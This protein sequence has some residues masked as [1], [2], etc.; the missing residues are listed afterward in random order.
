MTLQ[1]MR[2]TIARR[3]EDFRKMLKWSQKE[4]AEKVDGL[5]ASSIEKIEK[6]EM[7]PSPQ[8]LSRLA[9]ALGVMSDDLVRPYIIHIDYDKVQFRKLEKM[10]KKTVIAL[11]RK[12][13]LM[14]E[15]YVEVER[16][17]GKEA[18][19]TFDY[20]HIPV[21]TYKDAQ[22]IA[23]RFRKDM[24]W[25][26]LPVVSPIHQL[27]MRGIKVFILNEDESTN[28]D[29]DGM[30][31][32]EDKIA[33]VVLKKCENT[34]HDRFTL[35]HEMGHLLMNTG[36]ID[37]KEL[38]SLC[39]AFASEI[40]LPEE[41]FRKYIWEGSRIYPATLQ[42][43]Q[44]EWGISCAAQMYKAK[45]LNIITENRYIG[46]LVRL[47]RNKALKA[48]MEQS[49]FLPETTNRFQSLVYQAVD[50]FKITIAKAA[51]MLGITVEALNEMHELA[52]V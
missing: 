20:D 47:N 52:N 33:V 50:E 36:D 51:A 35:F 39:N 7:A 15:R 6:A 37:G 12:Y 22:N 34:E 44:R 9:E 40:L 11:Q 27:E 8:K 45:E 5:T 43:L 49:R 10:S 46:Y 24:G 3:I 17:L 21:A 1:E 18:L 16:L 26:L 38:E 29:F 48:E 2:K 4:L 13:G 25:D 30:C 19:F 42:M 23:R 14:L 41:V 31:Y 28:K 32:K